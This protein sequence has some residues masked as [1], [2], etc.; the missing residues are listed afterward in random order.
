MM[1]ISS[2]S[3]VLNTSD[4]SP[5]PGFGS[6]RISSESATSLPVPSS[7][8]PSSSLI[9]STDKAPPLISTVKSIPAVNL[10]PAPS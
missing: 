8:R 2:P 3:T 5:F 6:A 9:N 7:V 10:L 1:N 4:A